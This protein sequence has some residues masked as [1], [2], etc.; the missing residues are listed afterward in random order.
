MLVVQSKKKKVLVASS[1][2]RNSRLVYD[3][4]ST[5]EYRDNTVPYLGNHL[6][7][8]GAPFAIGNS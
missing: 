8:K 1:V 3:R 4:N 7:S 2:S 6:N 5:L